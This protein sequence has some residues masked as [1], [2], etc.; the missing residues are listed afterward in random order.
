MYNAPPPAG[1][2]LHLRALNP[3]AGARVLATGGSGSKAGEPLLM[4]EN[5]V[6][7][8]DDSVD[9]SRRK[10]FEPQ[11]AHSPF[12]GELMD[13]TNTETGAPH[14]LQTNS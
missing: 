2:K 10:S 8:T 4:A 6:I 14:A 12:T 3:S 1:R 5:G 13:R 11:R 7:T 9:T